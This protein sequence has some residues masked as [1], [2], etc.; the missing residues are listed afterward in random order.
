MSLRAQLGNL[1]LRPSAWYPEQQPA[2]AQGADKLFSGKEVRER[3]EKM[4]LTPLPSNGAWACR[5]VCVI[6]KKEE[7][8]N[9]TERTPGFYWR[10]LFRSE[11]GILVL[12]RNPIWMTPRSPL[13]RA[14]RKGEKTELDS[15]NIKIRSD[16]AKLR[17][18]D[19]IPRPAGHTLLPY[20]PC[21]IACSSQRLPHTDN[22][23]L[24]SP[25][26]QLENM[27]KEPLQ[28]DRYRG[29]DMPRQKHLLRMASVAQPSWPAIWPCLD[30]RIVPLALQARH[31]P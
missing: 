4:H 28:V 22:L 13:S 9:E 10:E 8:F 16:P 15:L 31:T 30:H 2:K 6:R 20:Q 1:L 29:R 11:D 23:S 14:I 26:H 3:V 27:P 17:P 5:Y 12:D 24:H 7:R 19:R 18:L 25:W 21:P